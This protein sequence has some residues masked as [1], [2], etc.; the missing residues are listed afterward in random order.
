MLWGQLGWERV[1]ANAGKSADDVVCCGLG[2]GCSGWWEFVRGE[3]RGGG[4]CRQLDQL[5]WGSVAGTE[6]RKDGS[7]DVAG[8]LWYAACIGGQLRCERMLAAAGCALMLR[9]A[10]WG[11]L[12]VGL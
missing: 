9:A 12:H 11:R 6:S 7:A 10:G 5:S 2:R 3:P 4:A 8:P 1:L